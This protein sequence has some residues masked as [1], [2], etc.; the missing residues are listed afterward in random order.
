MAALTGVRFP[1]DSRATGKIL[2]PVKGATTIFAGAIVCLNAT[3]YAVP[4]AV[5]PTLTAIGIAEETVINLGADG[6]KSVEVNTSAAK[7]DYL[8]ANDGPNPVAITHVGKS[9]Y[10]QDDQTVGSL[11]TSRS[12]AGLCTGVSAAGVWLRFG[13]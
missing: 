7:M 10:V 8:V 9:V 3:G 6:A 11:A 5:S 13:V 1:Q 2:A 12:I 4:G